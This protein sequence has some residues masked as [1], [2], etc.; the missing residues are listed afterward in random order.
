MNSYNRK[1]NTPLAPCPKYGMDSGERKESVNLPTRYFVRCASCGY[2][3]AGDTQSS[4]TAKWN[5]QIED[6]KVMIG[7]MKAV[8]KKGVGEIGEV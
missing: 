3:V 2:V 6:M 8:I 1:P 7:K 5:K 4:A